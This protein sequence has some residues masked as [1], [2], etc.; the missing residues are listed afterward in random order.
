MQSVKGVLIID[1]SIEEK[2]F[3]DENEIFACHY[4]HSKERNVN[5]INACFVSLSKP[6]DDFYPK[7]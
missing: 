7:R 5:G 1:D 6:V 3:T 2:P 4:D